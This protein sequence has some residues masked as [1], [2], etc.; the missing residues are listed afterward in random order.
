M[1]LSVFMHGSRNFQGIKYKIYVL[2]NYIYYI[3]YKFY[4]AV[5]NKSVTKLLATQFKSSHLALTPIIAK[6]YSGLN[7]T[8][9]SKKIVAN[10]NIQLTQTRTMT[11][12]TIWTAEKLLSLALLGVIPIC[13]TVGGPICDNI[14]AVTTTLHMH[15]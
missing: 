3:I 13:L 7:Q 9:L 4:I 14:F 1:A 12:S 6:Q 10:N 11:H 5:L 2:Y 15:W 8:N